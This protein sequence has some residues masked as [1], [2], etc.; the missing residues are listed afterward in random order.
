MTEREY[1]EVEEGEGVVTVVSI[2]V[3]DDGG[4]D[5]SGDGDG[6]DGDDGGDVDFKKD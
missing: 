5:D 4:S 2:V 3:D 1:Q 6:G